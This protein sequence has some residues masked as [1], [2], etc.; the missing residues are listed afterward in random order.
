MKYL[1]YTSTRKCSRDELRDIY[2]T[3][4]DFNA[5]KNITGILLYSD[6]KFI[7]YLEGEEL[8]LYHLFFDKISKDDRHKRVQLMSF[9]DHHKRY[10]PD[11]SMGEKTVTDGQIAMFDTFKE[12][13]KKKL[14]DM[15]GIDLET[16]ML[17]DI[18]R[19]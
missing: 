10:F 1:I 11:W 14:K 9:E 17:M 7:Q 4:R 2:E 8:D 19:D 5:K 15:V 6:K 18:W 13:K 16:Q 3:S 12:K